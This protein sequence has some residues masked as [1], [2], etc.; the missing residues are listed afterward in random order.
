MGIIFD[1]RKFNSKRSPAKEFDNVSEMRRFV[2]TAVDT[3]N[4]NENSFKLNKNSLVIKGKGTRFSGDPTLKTLKIM[5]SFKDVDPNDQETWKSA[6][7]DK[8][9]YK[10]KEG[11]I[12]VKETG[13]KDSLGS[14]YD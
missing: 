6:K 2:F 10:G 3:L 14:L 4:G 9:R 5:G 13:E 7:I 8:I 12:D 1:G 11:I